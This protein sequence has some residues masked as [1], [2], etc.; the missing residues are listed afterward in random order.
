MM[1]TLGSEALIFLGVDGKAAGAAGAAA[2]AAVGAAAGL[3][4]DVGVFW[5]SLILNLLLLSV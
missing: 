4:A 3:A 2:G 1:S 5:L